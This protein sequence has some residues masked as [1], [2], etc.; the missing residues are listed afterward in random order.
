MVYQYLSEIVMLTFMNTLFASISSIYAI[1]LL[2][3]ILIDQFLGEPPAKIHPVVWIGKYLK[4]TG[5]YLKQCFLPFFAF[6]AGTL[7]WLVGILLTSSITWVIQSYLLQLSWWAAGIALGLVLKP[8]FAWRML[9]SEVMAVEQAL[10]ISLEEGRNRLSGLVSRDTSSL[11][12]Q[13]VRESAIETLAENFNDSVIAPLF[14]FCLGG[15]PGAAIYRFANTADA[16]WGY[17]GEW[18]WAGKWAAWADDLLSWLPAR[19]TALLL[20][21]RPL[22][23]LLDL[24]RVTPSPNGGWTMGAMAL[25]L[26]VK[27][28]KPGVYTL[29]ETGQNAS[30]QTMTTAVKITK[31]TMFHGI[32]LALTALL[33]SGIIQVSVTQ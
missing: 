10:Q 13:E 27:L 1:A 2:T 11:S 22:Y 21:P 24:S 9:Y 25:K 18:E 6:T 32:L 14:W 23:R 29:N 5:K 33:T 20:F 3:A 15:L 16:M 7:V 28:S 17:R 30:S 4:M 8:L 19:L 12:E 31:Q 26:N